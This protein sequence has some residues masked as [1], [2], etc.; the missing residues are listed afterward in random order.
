MTVE[1]TD[2]IDIVARRPDGTLL[3]VI[4][5]HL[6]WEE[7]EQHKQLLTAKINSYCDYIRGE[8]F[9][10]DHP[11][12]SPKQVVILVAGQFPLETEGL[13]FFAKAAKQVSGLGVG[14]DFDC[15][16][17][18][19]NA[20]A[21]S[22]Q[23]VPEREGPVQPRP[24]P[25]RTVQRRLLGE[26]A[27]REVIVRRIRVAFG[28]LVVGSTGFSVYG[29]AFILG[30]REP[31]LWLRYLGGPV[32]TLV[33]L[34]ACYWMAIRSTRPALMVVLSL[35][36]AIAA[37]FT[38]VFGWLGVAFTAL[39]FRYWTRGQSLER[40]EEKTPKS[41]RASSAETTQTL[42]PKPPAVQQ[43]P[44]EPV[45]GANPQASPEKRGQLVLQLWTDRQF[46]ERSTDQSHYCFREDLPGR[47]TVLMVETDEL[48][49]PIQRAQAQAWAQ[50]DATLFDIALENFVRHHHPTIE[51]SE[52]G[53]SR[54][55]LIADD[56]HAEFSTAHALTIGRHK[57]L[58]GPGGA[59][60]TMPGSFVVCSPIVDRSVLD[61]GLP[62][63]L[64]VAEVPADDEADLGPQ[65]VYWWYSGRF[66]EVGIAESNGKKEVTMPEEFW[67]MLPTLPDPAIRH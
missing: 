43:S 42:A 52:L 49:A 26:T 13:A 20:R 66:Y 65:P 19:A 36:T 6:G 12:L 35:V 47:R 59:L 61:A 18:S 14:L 4:S 17:R 22:V 2:R 33:I 11:G 50:P 54:I 30:G 53:S 62:E 27:S 46:D 21:K 34:Y 51:W 8:D 25:K 31:A 37:S 55:A 56:E 1:E 58:T 67:S 7:P 23:P 38:L 29:I 15:P 3:L 10:A 41:V 40:T 48:V 16:T 39:V 64:R 45:R 44:R 5:D 9:A 24:K 57:G 63:L 60:V 28:A 32:T